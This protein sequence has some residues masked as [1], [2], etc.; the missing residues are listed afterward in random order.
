MTYLNSSRIKLLNKILS[1]FKYAE[2]SPED[3]DIFDDEQD[4]KSAVEW[5][6]SIRLF[7]DYRTGSVSSEIRP[8]EDEYYP[9]Y[10]IENI[11]WQKVFNIAN[12]YFDDLVVQSTE[13]YKLERQK[14]FITEALLKK[15]N[16]IE[17]DRFY[18]TEKNLHESYPQDFRSIYFFRG[19]ESIAKDTNIKI[20]E[21]KV[22]LVTEDKLS[23][24]TCYRVSLELLKD[25][26]Q[27]ANPYKKYLPSI[28]SPDE[29]I[30][31]FNPETSTLYF[32]GKEILIAK[33]K[34]TDQHQLLEVLFEKPDKLWNYDEIA[35]GMGTEF[36]KE[37]WK[38]Y[39]NAARA[40]N[41]KVAE[42]TTIKDF[43]VTSAKTVMINK[44]YL[45][46]TR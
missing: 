10:T 27:G 11:D 9:V 24:E 46:A 16:K 35:D 20:T 43:L 1:E 13:V 3:L 41:Q 22:Q 29:E 25:L 6:Y 17:D 30:L 4:L 5:A 15:K 23:K 32:Q 2:P 34:N 8:G 12:G 40:I 38:K 36:K 31:N 37:E 39:Y 44:R 28:N 19:L 18:F 14:A 33:S 45:P 26:T 21:V 42:G 7:K